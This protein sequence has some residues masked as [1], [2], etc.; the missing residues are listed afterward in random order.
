MVTIIEF[1]ILI[2]RTLFLGIRLLLRIPEII[3]VL[4]YQKYELLSIGVL[5]D[6]HC[7]RGR[8]V[9]KKGFKKAT[10]T[11]DMVGVNLF[12]HKDY[13]VSSEKF[14]VVGL[15]TKE[16]LLKILREAYGPKGFDCYYRYSSVNMDEWCTVVYV[17][18][19]NLFMVSDLEYAKACLLYKKFC[20][21]EEFSNYNK[22]LC[23]LDKNIKHPFVCLFP[24]V[25]VA[26]ENSCYKIET[27]NFKSR[28]YK[29]PS[30]HEL[31][32]LPGFLIALIFEVFSI[33]GIVR[34]HNNLEFLS[35]SVCSL[36]TLFSLIDLGYG[37]IKIDDSVEIRC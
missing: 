3:Y 37:T 9:T 26:I 13:F 14:M 30:I 31:C 28:R 4:N 21:D 32:Y 25:D 20:I 22:T 10:Y 24:G 33:A 16:K 2:F 23:I 36:I 18:G 35:W 1:I 12:T 34:A 29:K 5:L 11:A 17:I 8:N 6:I 7:S 27:Y 15:S 19:E